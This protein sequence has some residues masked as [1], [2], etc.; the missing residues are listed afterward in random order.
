MIKYA[1][2]DIRKVQAELGEK[3]ISSRINY[4]HMEEF[5]EKG[6]YF[7]EQYTSDE[8]QQRISELRE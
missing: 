7:M 4:L 2:V 6:T 8:V 3:E 1:F 5:L